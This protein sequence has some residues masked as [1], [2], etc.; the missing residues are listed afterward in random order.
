MVDRPIRVSVLER[1]F[2]SLQD[3]GIPL[4][5]C[6]Q[7]QHLGAMLETAQWTAKQTNAGFSVSFFWPTLA[8]HS[9][10]GCMLVKKPS[11]RRRR[12]KNRK[13]LN[14]DLEPNPCLSTKLTIPQVDE[15]I[16]EVEDSSAQSDV[17][18][19]PPKDQPIVLPELTEYLSQSST[20]SATVSDLDL[21]SCENITFE[22]S[23]A[24]GVRY[25]KDGMTD[26][27]TVTSRRQR[28]RRNP[29]SSS[30][31]SSSSGSSDLSFLADC[32]VEYRSLNGSPGLTYKN[33]RGSTTWLDSH[34]H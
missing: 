27:T 11:K 1:P 2:T 6:L 15:G 4:P 22:S 32:D 20:E 29:S 30:N 23:E 24:P 3:L 8:G 13:S 19:E 7:M 14:G 17:L 21:R 18:P 9:T 25:E 5:V 34:S 28:R 16:P 12:R 10:T 26:W 31:I 33:R